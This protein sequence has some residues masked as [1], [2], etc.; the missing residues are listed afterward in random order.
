MSS[1]ALEPLVINLH[2]AQMPSMSRI[3]PFR[4]NPSPQ[5]GHDPSPTSPSISGPDAVQHHASEFGTF[6]SISSSSKDRLAPD[7]FEFV[8]S[9]PL[10]RLPCVSCG[11]FDAPLWRRDVDGSLVCTTCGEF[12]CSIYPPFKA[13]PFA[14]AI[15]RTSVLHASACRLECCTLITSYHT[16]VVSACWSCLS[17]TTFLLQ[18]HGFQSLLIPHPTGTYFL[19]SGGGMAY[20]CPLAQLLI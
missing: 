12:R 10:S 1:L 7:E 18:G 20:S 9:S 13:M 6:E 11:T 14:S 5:V 2:D 19:T 17:R 8:A 4:P 3:Q 16:T 15:S